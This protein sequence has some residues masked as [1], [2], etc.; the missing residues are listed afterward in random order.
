M[1]WS[2]T[3]RLY[4]ADIAML[5]QARAMDT[6]AVLDTLAEHVSPSDAAGLRTIVGEIR[7]RI[8]RGGRFG[9]A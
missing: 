1:S 3:V 5:I 4:E 2:A 7:E 8:A 6:D 9:G